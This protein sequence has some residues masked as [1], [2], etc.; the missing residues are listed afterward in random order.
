MLKLES[1]RTSRTDDI[2]NA[3]KHIKSKIDWLRWPAV[4]LLF[5]LPYF[6]FPE[7]CTKEGLQFHDPPCMTH[8]YVDSGIPKFP[9]SVIDTLYLCCYV[10]LGSLIVI[11]LYDKKKKRSDVIRTVLMLILLTEATIYVILQLAGVV[12]E[13]AIARITNCAFLFLYLRILR[14]TWYQIGRVFLKSLTI[15]AMLIAL[16]VFY[17]YLGFCIYSHSLLDVSFNTIFSSLY[18]IWIM[19]TLSNFP[20]I[21]YIYYGRSRWNIFYFLSFVTIGLYLYL[22][23]LLAVVYENYKEIMDLDAL[24]Y[25]DKVEHFF[26]QLFH[27][28]DYKQV[29]YITVEELEKAL[30]GHEI[31]KHDNRLTSILYQIEH[32]L[33]G[34]V[35]HE[36]FEFVMIYT[37]T[38]FK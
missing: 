23:F 21:S 20:E 5:I 17:T 10:I 14:E 7:W 18:V 16:I 15:F 24:E 25:E 8:I 11:R 38:A 9:S 30:G 6:D 22:N 13:S 35:G 31:V 12:A 34:K 28:L 1:R 29:G 2:T 19:F 36:D 3:C 37:D 32:L 4:I 26:A 33:N 27:Q